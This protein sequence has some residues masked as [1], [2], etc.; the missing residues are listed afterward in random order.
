MF[1]TLA[2]MQRRHSLLAIT[3]AAFGVP[4]LAWSKPEDDDAPV[5]RAPRIVEALSGRD[6]VVDKPPAAGIAPGKP[7]T[8]APAVPP[9][10]PS[11][12]DL[13]VQF[14]FDSA[15]LRP[16]GKRQLD[17][18]AMALN[19]RTLRTS[20]FELAGHTDRVGSHAHNMRLSLER[21][22]AVKSYLMSAHNLPGQR[23]F[24]MG[25]G[26]TRL[27][28]PSRPDAAQNRRVEVRR[29]RAAAPAPSKMGGELVPT[30]R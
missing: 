25:F 4:G 6:I 20:A 17:E 16:Q 8:L 12:I 10:R 27:A 26:S 15:E 19:H 23:L 11:S 5:V 21:A 18:L 22:E 1:Q 3:A 30:P 28:D 7:Q 13:Q 9:Q 24:A 14:T 29:L 2:I